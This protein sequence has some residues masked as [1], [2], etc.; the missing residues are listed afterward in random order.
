MKKNRQD[1]NVIKIIYVSI[2]N[3]VADIL[4]YIYALSEMRE[5]LVLNN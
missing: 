3:Q 4:L 2:G 1:E 5:R